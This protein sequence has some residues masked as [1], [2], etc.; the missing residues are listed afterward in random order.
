MKKMMM[1]AAA[2]AVLAACGTKVSEPVGK[3]GRS[4]V[5]TSPISRGGIASE[6]PK[7]SPLLSPDAAA[8]CDRTLVLDGGVLKENRQ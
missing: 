8:I 3:R 2:A 1:L 7:R 6:S 5:S 4:S